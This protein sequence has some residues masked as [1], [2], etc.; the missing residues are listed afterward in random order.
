M[1]A[2]LVW[3]RYVSCKICGWY[4]GR[5]TGFLSYGLMDTHL[6]SKETKMSNCA[7]FQHGTTRSSE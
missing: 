5:A 1:A 7:V 2:V 4:L 6:S 3:L